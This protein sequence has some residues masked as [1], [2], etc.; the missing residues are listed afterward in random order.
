MK[1]FIGITVVLLVLVGAAVWQASSQGDTTKKWWAF[2]NMNSLDEAMKCAS[3]GDASTQL[4]AVYNSELD[5]VESRC[6]PKGLDN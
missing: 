1:T 3:E 2:M 6:Y 4:V 5:L